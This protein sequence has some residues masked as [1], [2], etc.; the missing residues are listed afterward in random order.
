MMYVPPRPV[1]QLADL[2]L[3]S[4]LRASGARLEQVVE[5]RVAGVKA[6][7]G[8]MPEADIHRESARQRIRWSY[9]SE[10]N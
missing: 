1:M 4:R 6:S 2:Q 10:S 3:L 5:M 9:G 7:I 8:P